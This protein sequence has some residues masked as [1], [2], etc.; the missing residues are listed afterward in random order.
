MRR[1]R[2]L[3]VLAVILLPVLAG[4]FLL[5]A[6][7][8]REGAVLLDQVLSLVSERFVDTLSSFGDPESTEEILAGLLARV[9]RD[10]KERGG[11]G[12]CR[13]RSNGGYRSKPGKGELVGLY[14]LEKAAGEFMLND[15]LS[16][17]RKN[18]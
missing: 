12:E 1:P 15:F 13:K 5:E 16:G 11:N 7:G 10:A 14:L 8:A 4:G 9:R 6:R 2:K 3:A 18:D 17:S